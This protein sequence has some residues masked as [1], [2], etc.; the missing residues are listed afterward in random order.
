MRDGRR[1]IIVGNV[2]EAGWNVPRQL[3]LYRRWGLED[4]LQVTISSSLFRARDVRTQAALAPLGNVVGVR[5][6]WPSSLFCDTDIEGRCVQTRAG[7]PL[8]RDDDHLSRFGASFVTPLIADAVVEA[9]DMPAP[10]I[11]LSTLSDASPHKES[12]H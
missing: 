6:I 3:A 9:L 5:F 8:Y 10:A 1:V 2:P 11:S 7:Q 4:Q 12:R